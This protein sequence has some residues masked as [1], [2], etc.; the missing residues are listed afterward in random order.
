MRARLPLLALLA[1]GTLA[2]CT[3]TAPAN[4]GSTYAPAAAQ[5]ASAVQYGV[6]TSVRTVALRDDGAAVAGAIFGGIVGGI[7]GDQFGSGSGNDIMTGVGV[8]GGALAGSQIAANNARSYAQEW[9]IR[10][11]NGRSIAVIQNGSYYVGQPVQVV[12]AADG[13]ARIVAR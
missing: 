10:M 11:D 6:I 2:A 4:Q 5:R 7:V 8:A 12:F 3:P 13:K 1:A 9:T